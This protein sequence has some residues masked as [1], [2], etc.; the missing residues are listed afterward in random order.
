VIAVCDASPLIAFSSVD[1]LYILQQLFDTVIIPFAVR[2]EVFSSA[3]SQIPLPDFIEVLPIVS[4][5]SARFL[6]MNL[7]AGE[8]EAIALALELE[9]ERIILD[10]KQAREVADR[11]G[12]KVIGTLGLLILAKRLLVEIRPIIK[13]LI[14]RIHFRIAP[15]VTNRA[16][17]QVGEISII[18]SRVRSGKNLKNQ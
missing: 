4:E 6:K 18:N 7:H 2:D 14:E 16:L 11:L 12:L 3:K 8:S 13:Q 9:V 17:V 1:K 10:D 5:T 15:A